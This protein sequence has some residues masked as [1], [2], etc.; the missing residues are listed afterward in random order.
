[1][2]YLV[3]A[4]QVGIVGFLAF[5]ALGLAVLWRLWQGRAQAMSSAMLGICLGL[6]VGAVF[7]PV[8]E[9]PA[10]FT[11]LWAFSAIAIA[12]APFAARVTQGAVRPAPNAGLPSLDSPTSGSSRPS[13]VG[14]AVNRR[15]SARTRR[16]R[17]PTRRPLP[18]AAA[19]AAPSAARADVVGHEVGQR[20]ARASG[21][22]RA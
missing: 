14:Q 2:W 13:P 11:P 1:M 20:A 3:Y 17:G 7:I 21:S 22:L 19:A 16:S 4:I 8:V 18:R 5:A 6:G 15:N 10:V 12:T 9:D